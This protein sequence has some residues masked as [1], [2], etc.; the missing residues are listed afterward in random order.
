[1]EIAFTSCIDAI[2][3]PVQPVW[4][5]IQARK[6]DVLLLL[7]DIAYMDYGLA[8]MG[9][10][11]PVGWPRKA[12]NETF[13]KAMHDRY[14]KQWEVK[15]FRD[16]LASGI[17]LGVIWDDHD[18]AWNNARGAGTEKHFAVPKEKRLIAQGLFRQFQSACSTPLA[19]HYPAMP[20]LAS[21]TGAAERGIQYN[22][23]VGKLRFIM[24]DGRSFREDPNIAPDASMLGYEQREW[25]AGLL[26]E[27]KGKGLSI[28]CSGSV[29]SGSGESW[30]QYLDYSWLIK[31]QVDN[32]IVLSGDIHKNVLPVKHQTNIFEVTSS[33]AAR[34]GL[35]GSLKHVGGARMNFGIL[36][37]GEDV[38]VNLFSEDN[39]E[40][41]R[42]TIKF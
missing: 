25:L 20:S 39:P 15:S 11:R 36:T 8:I 16:L 12:S 7:G 30:D 19:P 28:V 22:F 38:V 35:G 31:Q 4:Q 29:M 27:W 1:M 33:G 23:D 17:K 14:R 26:E 42:V 9:S 21:L 10:D 41:A 13:A 5:S 18:F 2:D 3:D 37:V 6:P 32:L 24:L 34:R 40:G